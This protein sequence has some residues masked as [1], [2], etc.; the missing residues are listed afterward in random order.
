[1]NR[2]FII[3]IF[4]LILLILILSLKI[5]NIYSYNNT[6]NNIGTAILVRVTIS[7]I[8]SAAS[9]VNSASHPSACTTPKLKINN[10]HKNILF[11][12]ITLLYK[13]YI[14]YSHN[15]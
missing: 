5:F 6:I 10:K 2:N 15:K 12:S 1:M 9:L 14:I 4:T 8:N 11:I 13:N 3:F 7:L